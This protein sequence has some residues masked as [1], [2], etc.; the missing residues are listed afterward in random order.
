M[1]TS[2]FTKTQ[3][4]AF[5]ILLVIFLA[6]IIFSIAILIYR[7]DKIP[8][9]IK[10]APYSSIVKL[11]NTTVKNDSTNYLLAGTYTLTV[12]LDHFNT[13]ST[14][15]TIDANTEY[16]LGQLIPNDSEG[17]DIAS[18]HQAEYSEVEGIYGQIANEEGAIIKDQYP[19]LNHLPINNNFYSISFRYE[20]ET[21]GKPLITVKAEPEYLDIATKKLLSFSNIN[22][23]EYD[24]T[25]TA[26]NPFTT[27]QNSTATNPKDFISA[28]YPL[29]NTEGYKLGN[30]AYSGDYYFTTIYQYNYSSD[31]AFGHY[32]IL[33]KK[34]D[35]LWQLVAT[36]QPLLT[37]YNTPN[38]PIDILTK[39]NQL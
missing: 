3:K 16:L 20:D 4:I 24:I 14:T 39:A 11:N 32:R 10:Y 35:N 23:A 6:C 2:N 27:P 37:L 30:E 22:P 18:T 25:F 36:P 33:L 19:I 38:T 34:V 9:Q 28:T 17:Q 8:V 13:I 7:S 12:E 15:V 1:K 5:L 21:P 31:T 26:K 29:I